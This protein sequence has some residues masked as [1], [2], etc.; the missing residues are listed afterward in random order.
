M[1][2]G[3]ANRTEC[4]AASDELLRRFGAS[5]HC[6]KAAYGLSETCSA[7]FYNLESPRYDLDRRNVFASAGKHLPDVLD[8]RILSLEGISPG[9]GLLQLRG[10]LVTRGYYNNTAATAACMT[11]D[12]WFDT[13]D[14]GLVIGSQ[15]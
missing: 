1:C 5:P 10:A 12:G 13:G 8:M 3:E 15:G 6:I 4:L 11:E 9:E 7:C 14:L 2:G